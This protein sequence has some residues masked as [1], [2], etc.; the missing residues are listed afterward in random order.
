MEGPRQRAAGVQ[1]VDDL[2]PHRR[3]VAAQDGG[4]PGLEQV[5]VPVAVDVPQLGPLRPGDDDGEGV[6][7]GEVVLH[8]AGDDLFRLGDHRLGPGAFGVKVVRRVRR[9]PVPA[10]GPDGL[11]DQLVEL[12]RHRRRVQVLVDCETVVGHCAVPPFLL[13]NRYSRHGIKGSTGREDCQWAGGG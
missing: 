3:D 12:R 11:G 2:L 8:P 7:E 9:Q 6:V 10:D 4:A 13:V 5:V 1:K